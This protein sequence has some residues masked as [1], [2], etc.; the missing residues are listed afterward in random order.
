MQFVRRWIAVF[1]HHRR[2]RHTI[3]CMIIV[4]ITAQC[5]E[6]RQRII[7]DLEVIT[8]IIDESFEMIVIG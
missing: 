6:M 7:K 1:G 3:P 2:C 4:V 5:S 8:V